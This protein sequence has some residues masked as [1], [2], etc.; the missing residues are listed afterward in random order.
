LEPVMITKDA[1]VNDLL[2]FYMGKNTPNRQQFII[3]NLK[4]EKDLVEQS[5]EEAAAASV[6][7]IARKLEENEVEV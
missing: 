5:A 4:V 2:G 1:K 7:A 6:R 3:G